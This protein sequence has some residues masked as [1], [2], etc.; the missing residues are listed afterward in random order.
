[1]ENFNC[2]KLESIIKDSK[3]NLVFGSSKFP[4][5][6][7]N[8]LT[9]SIVDSPKILVL[10]WFG[11]DENGDVDENDLISV[12]YQYVIS[13]CFNANDNQWLMDNGYNGDFLICADLAE[14]NDFLF[15]EWDENNNRIKVFPS[16]C[17]QP[18]D[19]MSDYDG[20]I[21]G[22][23]ETFDANWKITLYSKDA[24]EIIKDL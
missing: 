24:C 2:E 20:T 13:E 22:F 16:F 4:I 8:Q 17:R 5:T 15:E 9:I 1:M 7:E 6:P 18:K 14:Y 12:L 3:T 11:D 21:E 23:A 10:E 19:K